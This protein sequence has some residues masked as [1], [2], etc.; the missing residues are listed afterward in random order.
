MFFGLGVILSSSTIDKKLE[1]F[2]FIYKFKITNNFKF[3]FEIFVNFVLNFE[4]FVNFEFSF[5]I[6]VN[7][8]F[9]VGGR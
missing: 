1:I 6:C 5:D 4:I 9:F 2:E 3:I 7:F 8:E